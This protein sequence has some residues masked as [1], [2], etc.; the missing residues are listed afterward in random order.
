M[1]RLP[2]SSRQRFEEYKQEFLGSEKRP[3]SPADSKGKPDSK[4]GQRERSSWK[5]VLEFVR[6]LRGYRGSVVF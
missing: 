5:L 3:A 6:M 4:V 2:P 1:H